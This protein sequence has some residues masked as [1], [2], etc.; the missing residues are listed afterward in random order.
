MKLNNA[1]AYISTTPTTDTTSGTLASVNGGL[2][3]FDSPID[4]STVETK[5]ITVTGRVLSPNVSRVVINGTPATIDPAK[6]TFSLGAVELTTKENNLVYRV[7][8]VSGGLLSKGIITVYTTAN[9]LSAGTSTG[10][11]AR[12]QVETYKTD[13][14]FK[15]IAPS[16]DF[17]ETR[18]TKVKIE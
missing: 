11:S 1:P 15:I 16:T 3:L 7:F 14:R 18:E 12:A 8:D 6:Q 2:I 4:E 10:T 5:S 17:Y 9:G 13:N